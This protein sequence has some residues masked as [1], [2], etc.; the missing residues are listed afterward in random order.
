MKVKSKNIRGGVVYTE[1]GVGGEKRWKRRGGG[2][3]W[4]YEDI[5]SLYEKL[6][7]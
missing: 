7:R 6:L 1:M 3:R 4:G 2:V 5:E